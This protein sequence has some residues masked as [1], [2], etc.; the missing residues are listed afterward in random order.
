MKVALILCLLTVVSI[1]AHFARSCSNIIVSGGA[2]TDSS[3][4]LAYNADSSALYGSLY[5]Y[6][7]AD[8]PVGAMRDVYDWDSGRYL[9][10]IHEARHTYNVVGNMN[11]FGLTIGETT[12][13]G[14][15]QLQIQSG[16]KMD[17]GSAIWV[18]LQRSKTARE[19][20][21]TLGKLFDNYGWASEGESFSIIDNN[22]AW[23]MEIIGK[24]EYELGAVWVARKVPDGYVSA[25]ANQ[26]RI[27]TFP[28]ND[29]E[30]NTVYSK[31]VVSFAKKIGLYPESKSD[32]EFSFSDVYDPVTFSGAR[33]CEAR[34]WSFFGQ[35]M[36]DSWANQY[37]DYAMGYNLTN[38]MP[39]FVKPANGKISVADTMQ[40]MRNH[41]EGTAMDM[42]G[43]TFSDVGSVFSATPVRTHPLSWSSTVNPDGSKTE[44]PYTYFNERPIAT[45]QTGWNFVAQSRRWMPPQ[46][47]GVLW[48]GVDDSSTTV[49]FPIYGSA[50]TVPSTFAGKGPQDGVTTA[51]MTFSLQSAFYVFNL[52]ANWAYTR[53]DLMYPELYQEITS[54]EAAYMTALLEV[55]ANALKLIDEKGM[56]SAVDYVTNFST[57]VGNDLTQQWA[58]LF[59]KMFVKYRDGY[60]IN[61]NSESK[62]CGCSPNNGAYPQ[63]WYDRIVTDT[64]SHYYM[65][66][67]D[68]MDPKSSSNKQLH[69]NTFNGKFQSVDKM[70][71]LNRK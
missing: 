54:R 66:T 44:Q 23:V 8:H 18:T 19:A 30:N 59:G 35:I 58:V 34:V 55:D 36:G 38:R 62:S 10:Q 15:A 13:G 27:T 31:D 71:L 56:D 24:G 20:I 6:P 17:Y 14:I 4:I 26:A 37:L 47:S 60:V 16:A 9:G 42:T 70:A 46:L 57:Q 3:N 11:E 63:S 12:Y 50:T 39:L 40:Y 28:L 22:E 7:A 5:H 53:W 51:M 64:G 41:Y 65:G 33:Y 69:A 68:P 32:E 48:F 49:H 52:V 1:L 2:S 61:A 43:R 25:H 45:Q 29:P 21:S 67:W